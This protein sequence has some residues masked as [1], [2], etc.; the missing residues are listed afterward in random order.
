VRRT[1]FIALCV[2]V[3]IEMVLNVSTLLRELQASDF[4]TFYYSVSDYWRTGFLYARHSS[5]A[6]NLNAPHVSVLLF[7][8]LLLTDLRTAALLWDGLNLV[9][10]GVSLNLIR[11]GLQLTPWRFAWVTLVIALSIAAQ[12]TF[13]HAQ[14]GGL[15]CL[16]STLAWRATRDNDPRG[17]WWLA[18]A[19]SIKPWLAVGIFT[20][21]KDDARFT[22]MLGAIGVGIGVALIG[23]T[24]WIAWKQA[25]ST[26]LM[27]PA[28]ANLTLFTA[29][30][31]VVGHPIQAVWIV[32]SVALVAATAFRVWGSRD[33]DRAWVLWALA[34]MLISP[35][36]WSYYLIVVI[37][38]LVA[39]G[40]R[41]N[42][43][44]PALA[45]IAVLCIPDQI[46]VVLWVLAEPLGCVYA[47]ATLGL[48]A[49]VQ[50]TNVATGHSL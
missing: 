3:L 2:A 22:V 37:G 21:R 27:S 11:Q 38:P 25:L 29:I 10:I 8:P 24:N 26:G 9:L 41:A 43:P 45:A 20:Q 40:E 49:S 33:V 17:S 47:A 44:K 48:W 7:S 16:L 35:V 39:W 31:R 34:A 1:L 12:Q 32:L 18:L 6:Y 23:P 19:A 5:G 30:V 46:G 50:E 28:P 14:L 36:A 42:W 15:L 13:R 4:A